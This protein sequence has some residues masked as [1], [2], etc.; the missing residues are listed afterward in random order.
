[1]DSS[2]D[3]KTDL[4]QDMK[5]EQKHEAK[6]DERK[7]SQA[8][9]DGKAS[10][11]APSDMSKAHAPQSESKKDQGPVKQDGVRHV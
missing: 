10:T 11:P 5:S 7:S 6:P 9:F 8:N 2:P 4:K 3:K 1:M